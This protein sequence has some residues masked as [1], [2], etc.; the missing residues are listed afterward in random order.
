[1]FSYTKKIAHFFGAKKEFDARDGKWS[2]E[3]KINSNRQNRD[4]KKLLRVAWKKLQS[5]FVESAGQE[6]QIF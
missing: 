5:D 6:I 2:V 4:E 1:M 3:K